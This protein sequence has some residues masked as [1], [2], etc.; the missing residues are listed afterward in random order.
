MNAQNISQASEGY[1]AELP[2]ELNEMQRALI[3]RGFMS[4]SM[5]TVLLI[6]RGAQ[7]A[8]IKAELIQY[9]RTIGR[10]VADAR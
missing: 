8:A 9:A 1:E 10:D 6:E 4:G 5:A 2:S 7:P 3:R